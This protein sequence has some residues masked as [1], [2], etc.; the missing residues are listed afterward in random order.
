MGAAHEPR[1]RRDA[2]GR[3]LPSRRRLLT[4]ASTALLGGLAASV[5]GCRAD[6]RPPAGAPGLDALATRY[7]RLTR[8]LAQHQPSL[9]EVWLG[10]PASLGPRVPV[11]ALRGAITALLADLRQE[12][13]AATAAHGA[14]DGAGIAG[15]LLRARYLVAQVT[16]LDAAA[17]RLLGESQR[18]TDEAARVFAGHALPPRDPAAVD[19]WRRELAERLPGAGS[20][21]ERHA[22]FRRGAA[23]P[24]ARV[25]TVFRAAVDWCRAASRA[26][27]PL[28]EGETIA[29]SEAST[30]TWAGLSRPTGP[31]TSELRVSRQGG[32]DAAHLLQLA[33]H[34][35]VPGHHAQH[36]LAAAW[37]VERHGWHERQLLPAFGPHLLMAE[38]AADAGADLLLP[39][40]TRER[41]AAEVLLP[42]AGLAA[43]L[44]PTLVRVE[45][46][47]AGLDSEVAAIAA[48]YLDTTLS[49]DA[50]TTR[51]RDDAL[52][53]DPPG[54][55]A[56][57][58]KQRT[59]MLAYPLGRRLVLGALAAVPE[60]RRWAR[61]GSVAA[62][63][64]LEPWPWS[65]EPFS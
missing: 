35:G 2:S 25:E 27:L 50:A 56:F 6:S 15:R 10:A 48:D 30:G 46:L 51:L 47:A 63:C 44:A 59:K 34:E 49:A 37:L 32:A 54:L 9:V 20:L 36:V 39:L 16:A 24:A 60:S 5:L 18:F 61:L 21:A 17:G 65:G 19:A 14:D 43:S 12:R 31:R 13:D 40:A 42:A 22:A 26:V 8:Q 23:V 41:V 7:V 28:P 38:G 52:V 11:P 53:L 3:G 64:T 57:I 33:A 58:E 1:T 4:G 45:R 62:T 55:L 29:F